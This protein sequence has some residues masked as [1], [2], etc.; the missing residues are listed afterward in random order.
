TTRRCCRWRRRRPP[1]PPRRRRRPRGAQAAPA[2]VPEGAA[3]TMP[4]WRRSPRR[5]RRRADG[6]GTPCPSWWR[7]RS[8][9][10]LAVDRRRSCPARRDLQPAER[11][12]QQDGG[13]PWPG[14]LAAHREEPAEGLRVGGEDAL[15]GGRRPP[16]LHVQSRR[17]GPREELRAEGGERVRRVRGGRDGDALRVSVLQDAS[18][19]PPAVGMPPPPPSFGRAVLVHLE[20]VRRRPAGEAEPGVLLPGVGDPH[21]RLAQRVGAAGAHVADGEPQGAPDL[22]ERDDPGGRAGGRS[23]PRCG[24]RAPQGRGENRQWQLGRLRREPED[25]L[26]I[27]AR[28]TYPSLMVRD[29]AAVTVHVCRDSLVEGSFLASVQNCLQNGLAIPAAPSDWSREGV[30]EDPAAP[31]AGVGGALHAAQ[32]PARHAGDPRWQVRQP[33]SAHKHRLPG[34]V[35]GGA[36]LRP[37]PRTLPPEP[38]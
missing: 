14:R 35:Q 15:A 1:P 28:A 4:A 23:A 38:K 19:G 3:A 7:T 36:G 22:A 2:A 29:L 20:E 6:T 8:R 30:E 32:P 26:R 16:H 10:G 25:P 17:D 13:Q 21:Y 18:E 33:A 34:R 5:A 11:R 9:A 31:R 12:D 24:A 27:L 37:G